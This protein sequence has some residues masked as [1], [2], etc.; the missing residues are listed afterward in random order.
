M[1]KKY[2][3]P[4]ESDQQIIYRIDV[5]KLLF[6]EDNPRLASGR[7]G[8]SQEDLLRILWTEMGIDELAL[9]IS[10]NGFFPEE[11][12]FVIP[13]NA[14]EKDEEKKRY[15]VVEG[16]RRLAAVKLLRDK[17]LRER[18]KA[19]DLPTLSSKERKDLDKLPVAIYNN[20]EELWEYFGFRHINGP[21]PWDSFSKAKYIADVKDRYKV[22]LDEIARKIGDQRSTVKKLYRG[23]VTLLQAESQA[24]FDRED[25]IRN[26]F[27]FSHLYTA[28]DQQGYQEFLG[29]S[30][31]NSLKPNPVPKSKLKEL[32]ELMVWIYG[33]RAEEVQP[34]VRTQH[35]DLTI[36]REVISKP[37]A[38]SALRAGYSLERSYDVAK[39]D[40]LRFREALTKA[41]EDLMEAAGAV[42]LGY[43]GRGD[44][45]LDEMM[46]EIIFIAQDINES[47][48][49]KKAK[50]SSKSR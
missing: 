43:V 41:K 4:S 34:L 8:D 16:N 50:K 20:H 33:S 10:A 15:I 11:N 49:S 26:K 35:P 31:D 13:E 47:M 39:G 19:T 22:P 9:S 17:K 45:D 44:E 40:K 46:G 37:R 24:D 5:D 30:A 14:K 28:V 3:S 29:I 48:Q 18:I 6:D 1:T 27:Y 25:R 12:L 23:Y 36:L 42:A 21:K 7:G 2:K 38:L 32:H